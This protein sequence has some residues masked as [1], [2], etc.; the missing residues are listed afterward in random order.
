MW[1]SVI[2]PKLP[3]LTAITFTR[4][5]ISLVLTLKNKAFKEKKSVCSFSQR[6]H[7]CFVPCRNLLCSLPSLAFSSACFMASAHTFRSMTNSKLIL[8]EGVWVFLCENFTVLMLVPDET[9]LSL[10]KFPIH[11]SRANQLYPCVC[12]S[13]RVLSW[14]RRSGLQIPAG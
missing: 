5:A 9:V 10:H 2:K 4:G 3:G 1:V 11:L 13:S 8:Y 6:V 7:V 12:L 14:E